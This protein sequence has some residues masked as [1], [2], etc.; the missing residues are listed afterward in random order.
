MCICICDIYIYK[1]RY[2]LSFSEKSAYRKKD[3]DIKQYIFHNFPH[4]RDNMQH[5]SF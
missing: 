1:E 2:S 3:F 4:M 5:W